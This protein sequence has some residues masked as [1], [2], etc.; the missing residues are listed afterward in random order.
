MMFVSNSVPHVKCFCSNKNVLCVQ[1]MV[2]HFV[3]HPVLYHPTFCLSPP[4]TQLAAT[5]VMEFSISA[6]HRVPCVRKGV[7]WGGVGWRSI[8][9]YTRDLLSELTDQ[10]RVWS[11]GSFDWSTSQ[12]TEPNRRVYKNSRSQDHCMQV[13]QCWNW[14]LDG[15]AVLRFLWSR[16]TSLVRSITSYPAIQ[17]EYN[18]NNNTNINIQ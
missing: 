6:S 4:P 12:G 7:W 9:G 17:Y 18:N 1:W 16:E 8:W 3:C 2:W 15:V 11:V 10:A 13:E 14:R 5:L